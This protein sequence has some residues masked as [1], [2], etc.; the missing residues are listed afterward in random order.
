M[1]VVVLPAKNI[2][3]ID[4]FRLFLCLYANAWIIVIQ[5]NFLIL[6]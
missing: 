6:L 5:L 1:T 3:G 2:L 4:S